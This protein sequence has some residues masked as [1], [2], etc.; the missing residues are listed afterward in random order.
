M[1]VGVA[2]W[3]ISGSTE[4]IQPIPLGSWPLC[5]AS[6]VLQAPWNPSL[7]LVADNE[8][9]GSKTLF[10]FTLG[11]SGL[12]GQRELTMPPADAE[13]P[14]D[15]EAL[16]RVGDA[17]LVVG[18][19]SRNKDCEEKP[20]RQRLVLVRR[21]EGEGLETVAVLDSTT[22]DTAA[23][24][25]HAACQQRLFTNPPPTD[26]EAVCRALVAAEVAADAGSGC[27]VLN[28]EGAVGTD[29]RVW[30]GLRAPLVGGRAALLRLTTPLGEFRFDR[31]ALLEL[32][33]RGV[34][35]LALA[36][37]Q[38]WGIGGPTDDTAAPF[39]LWS[40]A[41][42]DLEAG[43]AIDP[44]ILR[45]NLATSSEGLAIVGGRAVIAVD[46]DQG[47][48]SGACGDPSRQYTLDI[49]ELAPVV[50]PGAPSER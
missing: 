28:I 12:T 10:G 23:R 42:A 41:L 31:V 47:K 8:E 43:G 14:R 29:G 26:S 46:G 45:R 27:D 3:P 20:K 2:V 19:H 34:R 39:A 17:V 13:R 11:D 24:S 18:S 21:G 48:T 9:A 7:I 5:E 33:Q 22:W 38:I 6:A 49:G 16:A 37:D 32:E 4:E 1:T 15:I 25:N 36:N 35:E 44:Q 50:G 40:I 30:L